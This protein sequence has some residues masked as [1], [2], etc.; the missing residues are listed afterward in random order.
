MTEQGSQKNTRKKR[1]S[2]RV[3]SNAMD[4]TAVVLVDRFVKHAKYNKYIKRSKKYKAHDP[5]NRA[6]VGD[7]VTI[8][9]SRPISKDKHFVIVTQ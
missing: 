2:G 8:E 7:K 4:K 1:L 6:Q 3:V 9:E 5:E